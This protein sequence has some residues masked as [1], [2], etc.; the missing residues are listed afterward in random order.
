MTWGRI[1]ARPPRSIRRNPQ[2][3]GGNPWLWPKRI[4]SS[5]RERPCRSW[6][7]VSSDAAA[8]PTEAPPP[9]EGLALARLHR[10]ASVCGGLVALIGATVLVGHA[11][12]VVALVRIRPE[13][14]AMVPAGAAMVLIVG[15]VVVM[16]CRR[17]GAR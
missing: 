16:D 6:K 7:V 3:R 5:R 2:T 13:L 1:G 11:L 8:V 15:L 12:D 17:G 14:P 9:T 10:L 4:G